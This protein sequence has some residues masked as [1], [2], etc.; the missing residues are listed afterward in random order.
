MKVS[1]IKIINFETFSPMLDP[2]LNPIC[3]NH[4]QGNDFFDDDKTVGI[5]NCRKYQEAFEDDT[6]S[7]ASTGSDS[8]TEQENVYLPPTTNVIRPT[9]MVLPTRHKAWQLTV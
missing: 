2:I 3:M 9:K 8:E 5:S 4:M 1:N 7:T 6:T